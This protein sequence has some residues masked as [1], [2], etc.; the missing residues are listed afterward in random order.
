MSTS[1]RPQRPPPPDVRPTELSAI[2]LTAASLSVA[3]A[4]RLPDRKP[5]QTLDVVSKPT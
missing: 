2:P 3:A 4:V 5:D 1:A